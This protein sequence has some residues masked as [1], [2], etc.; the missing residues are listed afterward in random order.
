MHLD[1]KGQILERMSTERGEDKLLVDVLLVSKVVLVSSYVT[2]SAR[3]AA[4]RPT[5]NFTLSP[6]RSQRPHPDTW[7]KAFISH[8]LHSLAMTLWLFFD[9]GPRPQT[10][11][12]S[13]AAPMAI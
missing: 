4:S 6:P 12:R 9:V 2:A 8:G 7:Y 13:P 3:L 11:A 1:L 10:A 5:S